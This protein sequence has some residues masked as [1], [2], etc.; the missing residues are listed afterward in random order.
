MNKHKKIQFAKDKR[1][2]E[3]TL[4][5]FTFKPNMKVVWNWTANPFCN[6]DEDG[7]CYVI[8]GTIAEDSKGPYLITKCSSGTK[9]HFDMLVRRPEGTAFSDYM[10]LRPY[11]IDPLRVEWRDHRGWFDKKNLKRPRLGIA[12]P[13]TPGINS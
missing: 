8:I 1:L 2:K 12:E 10:D 13:N 4:G 5:E 9:H 3:Y 6:V 11:L 7:R